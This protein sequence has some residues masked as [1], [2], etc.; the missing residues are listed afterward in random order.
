[1]R[2]KQAMQTAAS[3]QAS[4]RAPAF[5]LWV[6]IGLVVAPVLVRTTADPDLWGHVRFGLDMLA[7][8]TL[9]SLDP[10]SFTQDVPWVNH[11]W[12]SELVMAIAYRIGGPTGLIVLKAAL[13]GAFAALIVSAY[14]SVSPSIGAPALLLVAWG[15]ASQTSTLRPQLWTLIGVA[16]TCRLLMTA[17]RRSWLVVLPAVFVAW[18]NLHGGWIVGAGLLA[19]WTAI[20]MCRRGAPR[21]LILA[22]AAASACATLI[23]PYGWRMWEFLAGTVRMSREIRE[24]QPLFSLPIVDWMPWLLAVAAV[25][26][27]AFARPRPRVEFFAMIAMLAYASVRVSRLAPL[28]VV[29]V[30]L[31]LRPTLAASKLNR[32]LAIQPP[33]RA[34]F[35]G[36]MAGLLVV[37]VVSAAAMTRSARCIPLDGD[38]TADTVAG[39]ALANPE[40]RGKLVTW[41]DWGEFALWHFGPKLRVSMDG[42][43]ETIYSDS[44]LAGHYALYAGTPE[45]LAYLERLDP[46]YVWLPLSHSRVREWAQTHGY[47]V[48][49]TSAESFIA[50]RHDRP[51]LRVPDAPASACF[52][53]Y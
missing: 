4:H 32:P 24:W 28:C 30:V 50:V 5:V 22:I 19:V 26:L 39:R 43:R 52:P 2:Q 53:G 37:A 7:T 8:H 1:M 10:Y 9:P 25:A 47:R 49:V 51:R 29:A 3:E 17:P 35:R 6:V 11:E 36:L 18:V 15:T 12:L 41:F 40:I 48:D 34:A 44:V 13:V 45:G 21:G 14:V 33:T 23:N 42:R 46:D 16:F 27:S 31:L 20:Q 38:W